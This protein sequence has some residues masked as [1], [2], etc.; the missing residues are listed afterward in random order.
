MIER[1]IQTYYCDDIRHEVSGKLSYI[2][3]YNGEMIVSSFP[4]TLP[5]LCIALKVVTPITKP[6]ESLTIRITKNDDEL[7]KITVSDEQIEAARLG[8]KEAIKEGLLEAQ[9]FNYITAFS[10]FQLDGPCVV[11]VRAQTEC[12]ELRGLALSIKE[13]EIP[14]LK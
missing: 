11:R 3:M 6:M 5:K 8:S 14:Q 4:A 13:G 9:I 2:G 7:Q 1:H 12:E 10:P